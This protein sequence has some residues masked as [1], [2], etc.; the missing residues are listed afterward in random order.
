MVGM[1]DVWTAQVLS[2]AAGD[3]RWPHGT[4]ALI[5]ERKRVEEMQ[6]LCAVMAYG[7]FVNHKDESI[8]T[9][10]VSFEEAFVGSDADRIMLTDDL[11]TH[12]NSNWKREATARL[13]NITGNVGDEYLLQQCRAVKSLADTLFD[14][15]VERVLLLQALT[16]EL[17]PETR[18]LV[19][20]C[21]SFEDLLRC[22]LDA[23]E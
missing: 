1:D 7:H 2:G 8:Y 22:M 19:R 21:T 15:N 16:G 23:A 20:R 17:M 13:A 14:K 3:Y 4:R 9:F 5:A 11:R 12:Y 6:A 18:E 10:P